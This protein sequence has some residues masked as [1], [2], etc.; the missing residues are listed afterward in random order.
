[1]GTIIVIVAT[2][3]F[4][5]PQ[6]IFPVNPMPIRSLAAALLACAV[7][8]VPAAAQS[9]QADTVVPPALLRQ[10]VADERAEDNEVTEE[11]IAPLVSVYDR[12]DLDG[13]GTEEVFVAGTGIFFCGASGNCAAWIYRPLPGG[14]WR[15]LHGGGGLGLEILEE[16]TNGHPNL[17]EGAHFSAFEQYETTY[18]YNGERY[19]WAG[20]RKLAFVEDGAENEMREMF[21]VSSTVPERRAG[22][23]PEARTVTLHDVALDESGIS[24]SADYAACA[25]AAMTPGVLCG[26]PRLVLTRAGG[27]PASGERCFAL[28]VSDWEK[29]EEVG[30]AL[31]AERNAS[32][33]ALRPTPAQWEAIFGAQTL[34]LRDDSGAVTLGENAVDALRDFLYQVFGLNGIDPYEQEEG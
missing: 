24:V 22:S 21:H 1:M 15:R 3:V 30:E 34:E 28:V 11:E 4:P 20:T 5:L 27:R 14:G 31:C 10:L 2:F 19:V 25:P 7:L 12:R 23:G 17:M 8:A 32:V 9:A 26:R 33:V 16:R 18:A 29:S 13:D 6:S